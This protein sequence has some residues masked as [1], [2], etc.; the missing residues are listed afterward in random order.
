[1][2]LLFTATS[3]D[4]DGE[5]LFDQASLSF[6]AQP[7]NAKVTLLEHCCEKHFQLYPLDH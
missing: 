4:L 2:P 6:S 3:P 1:M 7:C 5:A